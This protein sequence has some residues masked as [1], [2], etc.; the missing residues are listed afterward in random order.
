MKF[1]LLSSKLN[2]NKV[3]VFAKLNLFYYKL[4]VEN[5]FKVLLNL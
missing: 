2:F 5:E 1:Y 4:F 3:I